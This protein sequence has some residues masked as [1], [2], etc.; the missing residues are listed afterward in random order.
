MRISVI[1][2]TYER[3][4]L[5]RLALL[6]LKHQSRPPEEVVITDDGSS[7][8]IV[9]VLREYGPG[10]RP[11][12]IKY[13]RQENRGFRL[14]R[15]RNNGVRESSGDYLV[16]WDQDL[17]ATRGYLHLFS[18]AG[19]RGEFLVAFPV[20]LTEKQSELVTTDMA[21]RCD[22]SSVLT[23]HQLKR[24]RRQY[25]K[26]SFYHRVGRVLPYKRHR[27]K[28]RGGCFGLMRDDLLRVDGFD[29]NYRGWGA[30]DDDLG[31]RLYRAG[32][33][34][35]TVFRDE[36]PMHLWHPHQTGTMDSP[37]L[38]YYSRRLR[39]IARGDY[40]AVSG[41]SNPLDA[42]VPAVEIIK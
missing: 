26:D 33:R 39:E 22:Y 7:A 10:L 4:D 16:F 42:D 37:N 3:P 36:F 13:V 27:P 21:A 23:E 1:V 24:I 6:C 14:A 20:L 9:S 17:V 40:M 15:S 35:R 29:E 38:P 31:R 25:L 28:V 34:G 12:S 11:G 2:S 30:E 8:D 5:L 41:L 32:V 18:K 19:R